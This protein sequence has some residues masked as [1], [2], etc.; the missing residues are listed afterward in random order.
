MSWFTSMPSFRDLEMIQLLRYWRHQQ[1]NEWG[2]GPADRSILTLGD[3][4]YLT[5]P[6]FRYGSVNEI[7]SAFDGV[8]RRPIEFFE[9]VQHQ[10]SVM[11]QIWDA[12]LHDKKQF[13]LAMLPRSDNREL[14]EAMLLCVKMIPLRAEL[15]PF[16]GGQPLPLPI[17]L[18]P[19]STDNTDTSMAGFTS[20][21]PTDLNFFSGGDTDEFVR[22]SDVMLLDSASQGPQIPSVELSTPEDNKNNAA[23]VAPKKGR[24]RTVSDRDGNDDYVEGPRRKRVR[25]GSRKPFA[26]NRPLQSL[27]PDPGNPG[28]NA[29]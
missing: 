18:M 2:P 25:K 7:A 28:P 24:K 23:A 10:L 1:T 6:M 11:L 13:D 27:L 29:H 26:H 8:M 20:G 19:I 22:P 4:M 15:V 3:K 17:D 21:I 12:I 14:L 5:D 16:P 9:G